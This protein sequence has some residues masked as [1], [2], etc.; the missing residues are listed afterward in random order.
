M[1]QLWARLSLP[2]AV[3]FKS[4]KYFFSLLMRGRR[5]G[6]K[7]RQE[8]E[9]AGRHNRGKRGKEEAGGGEGGKPVELEAPGLSSS[10][11]S[12]VCIL[13]SYTSGS[14]ITTVSPECSCLPLEEGEGD[15]RL[16]QLGIL[17]EGEGTV[18]WGM[19]AAEQ[20]PKPNYQD[21]PFNY[22]LSALHN[23]SDKP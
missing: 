22:Q 7:G 18:H 17:L 21:L 20:S 6:R 1:R 4:T 23:G 13:G 9:E 8:R 5:E 11:L 14:P 12:Q 3:G 16:S 10:S 15:G 19:G 2:T